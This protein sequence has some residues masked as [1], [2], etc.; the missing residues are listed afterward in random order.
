VIRV[1]LIYRDAAGELTGELVLDGGG[2]EMILDGIAFTGTIDGLAPGAPAPR[3]TTNE[4]GDLCACRLAFPLPITVIDEGHEVRATIF[5]ELEFPPPGEPAILVLELVA[6][7]RRVRSPG[8]SGWFEDELLALQ[9]ETGLQ[10][11][12][13]FGCGLSDY[14]PYGHGMFGDLM[15]FRTNKAAYRAVDSKGALFAIWGSGCGYVE[16]THA[17]DDFEPRRPGAGYRG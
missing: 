10:F 16:E 14:S 11:K 12:T 2:A 13:C 9:R 15:C 1:P 6:G 5:V 3:F 7:D 4:Y 17:C 8:R